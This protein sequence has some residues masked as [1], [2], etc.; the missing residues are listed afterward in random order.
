MV[1]VSIIIEVGIMRDKTLNKRLGLSALKS[2]LISD[3]VSQGKNV[4]NIKDLHERIHSP[5]AAR[6][7]ASD[8]LRSRWLESLGNGKYLVVDL[9]AGSKPLWVEDGFWVAANLVSPGYIGY[10]NALN[11]YGW[12]EQVPQTITIATTKR[13]RSRILLGIRYE[14]VTLSKKKFFGFEK[15]FIR[16][17]PI[18]ISN[19]EK[20]VVDSLDHPE[21]CGGIT[22]VAKALYNARKEVKWPLVLEYAIQTG[23]GAILKRLGFLAEKMEVDLPRE[24]IETIHRQKTAGYAPLAP[25]QPAKG[26]RNS[27]WGVLVNT[28]LNRDVILE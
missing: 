15:R 1:L 17:K 7:I 8:L 13:L 21:Y 24:V 16:G 11:H 23:N 6:R 18:F 5:S 20:T 9:S 10:Y 26:R 25:N 27:K 12:T 14:F 4:F 22:E 28:V 19:P 2:Q 3:L